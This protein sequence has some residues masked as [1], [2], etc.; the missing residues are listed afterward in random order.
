MAER[1]IA[2]GRVLTLAQAEIHTSVLLDA[3]LRGLDRPKASFSVLRLPR[4]RYWDGSRLN[5]DRRTS[6]AIQDRSA[7]DVCPARASPIVNRSLLPFARLRVLAHL[8]LRG[9]RQFP[10]LIINRPDHFFQPVAVAVY[11]A[12]IR[13]NHQHAVPA[14]HALGPFFI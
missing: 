5:D 13:V 9:F 10:H 6:V 11:I 8:C 1:I 12:V 3:C 7:C 4:Q 14:S 2:P